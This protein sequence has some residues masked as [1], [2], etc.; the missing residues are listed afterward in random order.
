M[1]FTNFNALM[2]SYL[3]IEPMNCIIEATPE[4][5]A[6]WLGNIEAAQDTELLKKHQIKAVLTVAARTGLSYLKN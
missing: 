3:K 1:Y 2:S 6:I 4:L 5:G